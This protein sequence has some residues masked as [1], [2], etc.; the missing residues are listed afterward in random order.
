LGAPYGA[1]FTD[2]TSDMMHNTGIVVLK[3]FVTIT[4]SAEVATNLTFMSILAMAGLI[5]YLV[6]LELGIK[7]WIAIVTSSVFG[8]SPFMIMRNFGHIVLTE[9]YFVPLSVLLCFWIYEREDIFRFDKNFFHVPRNYFAVLFLLLIANNGIAYYPFFTCFILLVTGVSKALKEGKFRYILHAMKFVAG[10]CI[11]VVLSIM[12]HFI[13]VLHNGTN[14][15]AIVRSGGFAES[16][17]YGLKIIQ[18]FLPVDGHNIPFIQKAITT[19][20]TTSGYVNEN[21][22]SYIGLVGVVGFI[23]LLVTFFIKQKSNVTQRL[24]FLAELNL[25]LVLLGTIGGFGTI[26]AFLVSD[27]IRGYNRISIYITYVCVLAFAILMNGFYEKHRKYSVI[28]LV[29]FFCIFAMFEGFPRGYIPD[30]DTNKF[31]YESDDRFVKKIEATVSKEAMI[32][33][34][35]YHKYPEG[36]PVN[37][38]QDYHLFIGFIHSDYLRWSYGSIKGR[39]GDKWNESISE[40]SYSDMVT[41]LKKAGFEGIYIDRRAYTEDQKESMEAQLQQIT[42]T[43][44]I[45]SENGNLSFF[46]LQ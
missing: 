39:E 15:D 27:Q 19:Y 42:G 7:N 18:L 5:S 20:N 28:A 23:I 31:N 45:V 3:I 33:Q 1:N 4:G 44:P 25:M 22:T 11:F 26:F 41:E 24:G 12:P 16:E 2:F 32:Y 8:F 14:A 10:I 40:L 29:S 38:M 43:V 21:I 9:A 6:M 46:K 37:Q 30:Y 17:I 36:G 34:L 13:Y 35:P